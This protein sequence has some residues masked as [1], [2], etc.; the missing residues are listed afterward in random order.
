MIA[1]RQ[2]EDVSRGLGHLQ[3]NDLFGLAR[4]ASAATQSVTK[5]DRDSVIFW[6]GETQDQTYCVIEGCI[7]AVCLKR[8]GGRQILA[9][10][11]P[12]DVVGS[13]F[14]H[15]SFYTAEAVTHCTLRGAKALPLATGEPLIMADP[16]LQETLALLDAISHRCSLSRIAWWLLRMEKHFPPSLTF[17]DAVRFVV[18][19]RDISDHI[20]TSLETVCRGLKELEHRG[21]IDLPNS[22]TIRFRRPEELRRIAGGE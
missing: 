4:D 7:R 21:I 19:R 18:P 9:F 15:P 3:G 12:G 2:S 5:R 14:R 16:V 1:M 20:G 17:D 11:W 6:Q 22:K 8:D 13:C 10:F